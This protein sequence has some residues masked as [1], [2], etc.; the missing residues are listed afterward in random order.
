M[1][2]LFGSLRETAD[3]WR[4]NNERQSG[5]VVLIW[6]GT[7]YGWKDCL[8]DAAHEQPGAFAVDDAGHVFVA[9]GGNAY[10]GAKCW[11]AAGSQATC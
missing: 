4:A 6:N 9:E 3:R 10:D 2:K 8:R 11:V 7:V 5:G 1:A